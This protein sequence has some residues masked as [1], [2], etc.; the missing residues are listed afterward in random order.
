MP[1]PPTQGCG[2]AKTY[3]ATVKE[4]KAQVSRR[5][6]DTTRHRPE[7]LRAWDIVVRDVFAAL[8]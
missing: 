2:V 3:Q 4:V 5:L 1:A 6:I 7:Q 8:I